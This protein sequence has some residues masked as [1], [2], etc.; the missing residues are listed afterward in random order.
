MCACYILGPLCAHVICWDH[1]VRMLYVGTTV[2][3]CVGARVCACVGGIAGQP[4]CV[5]TA[6]S[7][8]SVN[9]QGVRLRKESWRNVMLL[10][11]CMANQSSERNPN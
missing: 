2:C 3:A 4:I 11:T 9:R 5:G 8:E 6:E 1:C 7:S 10:I